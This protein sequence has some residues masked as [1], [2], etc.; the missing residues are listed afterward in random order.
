MKT[1]THTDVYGRIKER[2]LWRINFM[3]K[4]ASDNRPA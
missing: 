4:V 2:L 3:G 1:F